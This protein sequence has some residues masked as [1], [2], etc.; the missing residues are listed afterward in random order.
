MYSEEKNDILMRVYRLIYA[1]KNGELGGEVMPEDE[2]P[3][4]PKDSAENYAYFTLPM[5]LNYQRNSYT[6][7]KCAYQSYIDTDTR[8]IFNPLA[9][10]EMDAE[11]L[12]EKLLKYKV[13][14]QPNKQPLIWKTICISLAGFFGGDIRNL[15]SECGYSVM[16]V[17]RFF[18]DN[19]SSFPYLGGEKILNYWLFVMQSYTDLSFIDRNLI[20]V[21]P[22][23]HVIQSSVRL[24]LITEEQA[25]RSDIRQIVAAQWSEL[26]EATALQPIDAHTP[27]WL[28]SRGKFTVDI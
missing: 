2:N 6:L 15:F 3:G 28:W 24:G 20:T 25:V 7:W 17:K 18:L 23:T 11:I 27:L 12:K 14:L 10:A 4:L 9:V 21:A 16:K 22:D 19:K 5:S 26:L 1:Y 13:A 8:D